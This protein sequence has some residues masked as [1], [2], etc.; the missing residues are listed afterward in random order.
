MRRLPPAL[1]LILA[2]PASAQP[3]GWQ[4]GQLATR[5]AHIVPAVGSCWKAPAGL[6][7]FEA[8]AVTVRFALRDDGSLLGEPRISYAKAPA[9]E[10]T[11]T[12]LARSALDAV[13]ACT[14]VALSPGLGQ[15]IAGR[16]FSIRFTYKGPQ[17]RGA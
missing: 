3:A 6:H 13:R 5:L 8:L 4:Q 7:G 14:P 17:G 15:A 12:V 11:R 2:V 9:E 10:Q 16:I 1:A